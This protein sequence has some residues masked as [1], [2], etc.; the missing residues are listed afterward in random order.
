MVVVLSEKY[1]FLILSPAKTATKAIFSYYRTIN[2]AEQYK[3]GWHSDIHHT[4]KQSKNY[5]INLKN[6][7]KYCFIRDPIDR[8]I[9]MFHM[10][11]QYYSLSDRKSKFKSSLMSDNML[12]MEKYYKHN[13]EIWVDQVFKFEDLKNSIKLIN[14]AHNINLPEFKV[15]SSDYDVN[16]KEWL[17]IETINYICD[18]EKE[19]FKLINSI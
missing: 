18:R 1:N 4:I 10:T 5:K 7:K 2:Q 13:N 19:T 6:I 15:R 14:Q 3:L 17:D 11:Y 9:S 16:Y 12:P 8:A